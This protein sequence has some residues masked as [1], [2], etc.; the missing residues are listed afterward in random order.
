MNKSHNKDSGWLDISIADLNTISL[1]NET[2]NFG[3][4]ARIMGIN[5][6]LVSYRVQKI[7]ECLGF[8]IF[9]RDGKTL[10]KP[11]MLGYRLIQSAQ[12]ILAI[13]LR[14]FPDALESNGV[15]LSTG[16]VPA[17]TFLPRLIRIFE[18][19]YSGRVKLEVCNNLSVLNN[20]IR[21]KT[22][23]GIVSFMN[24]KEIKGYLPLIS[25][26]KIF[27][28]EIILICPNAWENE[29]KPPI[30][31]DLLSNLIENKPFIGRTRGSGMAALLEQWF[32]RND[33]PLPEPKY[34]FINSSS[35][36]SAVF[37]GMGF[38]MVYKTQVSPLLDTG[39]ILG[40]SVDPPL[41][42]NFN[43]IFRKDSV[44]QETLRFAK[45]IET[46]LIGE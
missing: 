28:D 17:L 1:I 29:F 23:I 3:K 41:F 9:E 10:G 11:T 20:V 44:D 22:S 18:S 13:I 16:E 42:Q 26:K 21:R 12:N 43:L 36:I 45:F 15:N 32:R 38:S 34:S 2:R 35:V 40:F 30:S 37:R 46:S 25:H 31:L 5:K 24:F 19:H 27:S 6:S 39:M 33:I 7:E 4:V 14:N 8:K